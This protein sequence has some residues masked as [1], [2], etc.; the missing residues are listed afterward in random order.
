[1]MANGFFE[2]LIN[3][4]I[5][6]SKRVKTETGISSGATSV[7]FAAVQYIINNVENISNKIFFYL[8]PEKLEKIPVRI[9]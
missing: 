8:E 3:S 4:V 2:R 5:Q 1:M 6:A 9:L 7:S